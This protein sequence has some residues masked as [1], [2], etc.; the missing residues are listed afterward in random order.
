MNTAPVVLFVYNRPAHTLKT[1][2]ALEAN[3]L[4]KETL[5]IIYADGPG[6][7]ESVEKMERIRRTREIIRSFTWSGKVEIYEADT[8]NG[9]ARSV[10][11]GVTKT[12]NKYGK[13]IVLEDDLVVAKGF[14]QY[15]NNAL[16]KYAGQEKVMQIS[17]FMFPIEEHPRANSAFF[18]PVTTSWG[19]AT[20]KR[21]WDKFDGNAKDYEQL[22][23]NRKYAYKFDLNGTYPYTSMLITQMEGTGVDSWAIRWWWSVFKEKGLVLY[24]GQALVENI[25]FGKDATH[26]SGSNELFGS[27]NWNAERWIDDFPA[28]PFADERVFK[29]L[30]K[31]LGGHGTIP[32]KTAWFKR[33][34]QRHERGLLK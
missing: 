5:L 22:K 2:E 19:W 30:L 3:D 8:N 9:L 33:I 14:L 34:L 31:H 25:G 1:L 15:M 11:N 18:L 6:E 12:I 24:P 21:A 28:E 29:G 23:S 27:A 10:I 4:S 32:K 26:T 20:W 17:G 13:A 16:D 7:N